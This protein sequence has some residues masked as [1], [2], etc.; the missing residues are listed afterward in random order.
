MIQ[1]LLKMAGSSKK[2]IASLAGNALMICFKY[3]SWNPKYLVLLNTLIGDKN[4]F[5]RLAVTASLRMLCEM[6]ST[7]DSYKFSIDSKENLDQI[8][9]LCK[10]SLQDAVESVRDCGKDCFSYINLMWPEMGESMLATLDVP[11]RKALLKSKLPKLTELVLPQISM[12][13][14]QEKKVKPN[15]GETNEKLGGKQHVDLTKNDSSITFLPKE[16]SILEDLISSD[17]SI[18]LRAYYELLNFAQE[19]NLACISLNVLKE[20]LLSLYDT[21]DVS[22][23]KELVNLGY[24][25]I[26]LEYSVVA[27]SDVLPLIVKASFSC[28]RKE[29]TLEAEKFLAFMQVNC[30][31]AHSLAAIFQVLAPS[32][33]FGFKIKKSNE[34]KKIELLV[35]QKLLECADKIMDIEGSSD[36]S[37]VKDF[38]LQDSNTRVS[39]NNLAPILSHSLHEE[40][41]KKIACNMMKQIFNINPVIF[42]RALES[43]DFEMSCQI[44]D[45]LDISSPSKSADAG[46]E[47]PRGVEELSQN[48][49]LI[50]GHDLLDMSFGEMEMADESIPDNFENISLLKAND[51][52]L[53]YNKYLYQEEPDKYSENKHL[54]QMIPTALEDVK[55]LG[56]VYLSPQK[57]TFREN[58][59]SC[60]I[61][62]LSVQRLHSHAKK[63]PHKSRNGIDKKAD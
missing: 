57:D 42:K 26:L 32:K 59:Y 34:E 39:V 30:N 27:M 6:A 54:S 10:R 50:E 28:N 43:L 36:P 51:K 23:L 24:M 53:S 15:D 5:I 35:T 61:V 38:F 18:Q 12:S 52:S 46:Y 37:G 4:G 19:G 60:M 47:I 14:E 62:L 7:D 8:G 13:P 33:R 49:S 1:P 44:K 25:E 22:L 63:H 41:V 9:K 29:I 55:K 11:I 16:E 20:R 2:M 17:S 3:T 45:I 58:R 21:K 31:V 40:S 56:N 48:I